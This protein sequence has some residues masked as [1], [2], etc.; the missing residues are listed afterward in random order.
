M[1][2]DPQSAGEPKDGST[3][4]P[5]L[6][7]AVVLAA[8]VPLALWQPGLWLLIPFAVLYATH[9]SFDDYG[10]CWQWGSPSF[11]AAT[12]A[13]A[14]GGYAAGH[15]LFGHF[16]QGRPFHPTLP[17]DFPWL[18]FHQIVDVA[19][20]EEFFFR[21]YLQTNLNRAWGRPFRVL[22]A[23]WGW[24]LPVSALIFALCH[25]FY[26]G[27]TQFK[28]VVFGLF[29]GWLRERTGS[30]AAPVLYHAAGNILLYSMI[31]GFA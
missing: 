14:L 11:L 29:A 25:L 12:A 10:I 8:T 17:P 16:V 4:H 6:E 26:G 22:G 13:V 1:N 19:L 31:A 2:G 30:I 21:G 5:L 3:P 20:P 7:S 23:D 18:V 15:Y 28:V 27:P 24:A 9:R